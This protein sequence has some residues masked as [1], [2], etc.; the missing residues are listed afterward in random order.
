MEKK[1]RDRE[2]ERKKKE[3]RRNHGLFTFI[4]SSFLEKISSSLI[5]PLPLSSPSVYDFGTGKEVEKK[6]ERKKNKEK[7]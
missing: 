1:E 3:E 7:V 5:S 6:K 4:F 2:K